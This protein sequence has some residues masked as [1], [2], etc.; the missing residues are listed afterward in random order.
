M[1]NVSRL[2]FLTVAAY[3]SDFCQILV[4]KVKKKKGKK[5]AMSVW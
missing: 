1:V 3:S 5:K 4:A 2:C